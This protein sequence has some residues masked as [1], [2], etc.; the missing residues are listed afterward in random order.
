MKRTY[1]LPPLLLL[2]GA[3]ALPAQFCLPSITPLNGVAVNLVPTDADG[4]GLTDGASATVRAGELIRF[5]NNPCNSGPLSYRIRKSGT[6]TGVPTDTEVSFDCDDLGVQLVDV[7][8]GDSAGVWVN[9]PTY[10]LVQDNGNVCS[11]NAPVL[12]S[13]CADDETPPQLVV[14]N[15]LAASFVPNPEGDGSVKITA[16]N[17]IVRKT[18]NCGGAVKA[19]IR[20]SGTGTGVPST[21]FVT[22]DCDEAGVQ[23]VEIW[24][25]DLSGNWDYVETYVRLTDTDDVCDNPV[26]AGCAPDQ[27]PPTLLAYNGFV[28]N[29]GFHN[30]TVKAL[31]CAKP[32]LRLRQDNCDTNGLDFRIGFDDGSSTPPPSPIMYVTCDDLGAQIIGVWAGDDAGNWTRVYTYILVEDS[33]GLCGSPRIADQ[34]WPDWKSPL[35]AQADL[36]TE[37]ATVAEAVDFAVQPNPTT[38]AFV[39]RGVLENA[40]FARFDLYNAFGQKVRTLAERQWLP[41]GEFQLGFETGELP[42][43]MYWCVLQTDGATKSMALIKN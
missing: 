29:L 19:R 26:Q 31:V 9:V 10:V 38:G 23:L 8:G 7:W 43:G 4:D 36:R 24:G 14:L 39:V 28:V 41:A 35:L 6:G 42:A 32:F 33:D 27:I 34:P 1:F 25:R 15:G 13:D 40:G 17:F 20:K 22:F 30:G 11:G 3:V 5:S 21:T 16:S 12:S 2:T 18:D 37:P